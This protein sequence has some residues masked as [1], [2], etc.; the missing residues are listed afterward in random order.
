MGQIFLAELCPVIV[1]KVKLS[2]NQEASS[3]TNDNTGLVCRGA[4]VQ[5]LSLQHNFSQQSLNSGSVQVQ[6]L[7][8][9]YRRFAMVRIS[10]S[11][12]GWK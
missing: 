5:W 1:G 12:P 10:D 6:I 8:A 4:V 9:A 7:L 2:N 3:S 11:G